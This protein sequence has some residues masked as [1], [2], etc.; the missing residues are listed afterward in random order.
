MTDNTLLIDV[1]QRGVA[2]LTM[3]RPE[4]RN[5]FDEDMIDRLRG[6]VRDFAANDDVRVLVLT[7]A[8]KAFSSGADLSMMHR[9]GASS[10]A[11]N[12]KGAGGMAE[13][14]VDLYRSPKPVV[15]MVNGP[16]FGG[17]VGLVA[18]C[19][20][21]IGSDDA[22]FALSEAR[23]GI[24]PAVISPFVVEAIGARQARRY[25]TTGERFSAA[26]AARIGLLHRTAPPATLEAA[27]ETTLADLLAC[28]PKAQALCKQLIEKVK[29]RKID[30]NV[31][32]ETAGMIAAARSSDE[33]MEGIAAFLQKRK[34][35]W[36]KG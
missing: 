8:G 15:A 1:D 26:D 7:G 21:A 18:A 33:G 5:A 4:M 24:I 13:M 14:L 25:F 32:D 3:N 31:M 22:Y 28:G 11:E 17:G 30:Q 10:G 35:N 23:L 29:D 6:A 16:A 34:P 2:R 27:L 19:D 20:I 36:V 12:R 9:A